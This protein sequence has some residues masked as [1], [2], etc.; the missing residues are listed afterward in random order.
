VY[1]NYYTLTEKGFFDM[2]ILE[3]LAMAWVN[4]FSNASTC[5]SWV[6]MPP[7]A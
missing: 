2:P 5:T 4:S 6:P 1:Y 7:S 3:Q